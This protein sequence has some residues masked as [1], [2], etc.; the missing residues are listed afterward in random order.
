MKLSE[1]IRLGA[2][3]RPQGFGR[4][5]DKRNGG[6]CAFGA[7][8]EACGIDVTDDKATGAAKLAW[9]GFYASLMGVPCPVC[10]ASGSVTIPHLNDHHHWTRERIADWVESIEN[11]LDASKEAPCASSA[12]M[13][14]SE[15]STGA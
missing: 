4:S 6:T 5:Y 13:P 14:I 9:Y 7:A 10:N 15:V 1:A 8:C 2:M 3:L 11:T 12:S